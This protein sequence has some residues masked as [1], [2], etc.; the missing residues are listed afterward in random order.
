M[1]KGRWTEIL[2]RTALTFFVLAPFLCCFTDVCG[3]VQTG[4]FRRDPAIG[5]PLLEKPKEKE[6][7]QNA[8]KSIL[9]RDIDG[10][11]SWVVEG[12]NVWKVMQA[13]AEL[14]RYIGRL[15]KANK[16]K[17]AKKSKKAKTDK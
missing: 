5:G 17:K 3:A 14:R 16:A 9:K 1:T 2:K 4:G 8:T 15:E 11:Y 6:N 7:A 12:P 13:D 10:R